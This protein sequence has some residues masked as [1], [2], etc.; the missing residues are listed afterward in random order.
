MVILDFFPKDSVIMRFLYT[1]KART[2][3]RY[4]LYTYML[5]YIMYICACIYTNKHTHVCM[6]RL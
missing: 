2:L 1:L 4:V 3:L 6:F 5:T